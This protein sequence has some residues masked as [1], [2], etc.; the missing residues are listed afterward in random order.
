MLFRSFLSPEKNAIIKSFRSAGGKGLAGFIDSLSL[1]W[2]TGTW[3]A[4]SESP[5]EFVVP[6]MCKVTISFTPIHDIS[7]GLSHDGFN[8]APIYPAGTLTKKKVEGQ[9]NNTNSGGG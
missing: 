1:D 9:K 7:P 5:P 6:K 8:R 2:N 4:D 3:T